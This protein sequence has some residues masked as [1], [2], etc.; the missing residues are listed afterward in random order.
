MQIKLGVD[1]VSISEISTLVQN[2]KTMRRTFSETEILWCQ[3]RHDDMFPA[4][5]RTFAAKEALMKA[6]GE[7]E[8]H[9]NKIE[10]M[11]ERE[12]NY[13][14]KWDKLPRGCQ[15]ALSTSYSEP[16]AIAIVTILLQEAHD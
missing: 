1:I 6:L 7:Q 10:V 2:P 14:V 16:F 5:A 11:R 13:R 9:L 3:E 12:R 15:V 4:F 8:G